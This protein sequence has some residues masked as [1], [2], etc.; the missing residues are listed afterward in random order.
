MCF[1]VG[2]AGAGNKRGTV[3]PQFLIVGKKTWGIV[4]DGYFFL[5]SY[6]FEE[7]AN[8]KFREENIW[9]SWIDGCKLTK[10]YME[11]RGKRREKKVGDPLTTGSN[12]LSNLCLCLVG[13]EEVSRLLAVC[14]HHY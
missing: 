3:G 1:L 7:L 9:N 2:E 6:Q 5:F 13:L 8:N 11:K 12:E 4:G 10:F 14:W